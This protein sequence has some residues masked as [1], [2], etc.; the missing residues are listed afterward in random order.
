MNRDQAVV[1]K[2]KLN[3]IWSQTWRPKHGGMMERNRHLNCSVISTSINA[4]TAPRAHLEDAP[5]QSACENVLN[6]LP[7]EARSKL[8]PN[9]L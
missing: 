2:P 9:R 6:R 3:L 8:R 1:I 5:T 7:G 4:K